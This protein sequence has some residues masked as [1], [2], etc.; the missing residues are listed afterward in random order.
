MGMM[1]HLFKVQD[2]THCFENM[3]MNHGVNNLLARV[4]EPCLANMQSFKGRQLTFKKK[5]P[6]HETKQSWNYSNVIESI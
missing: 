5:N 3:R 4:F 2:I 6:L 1:Q